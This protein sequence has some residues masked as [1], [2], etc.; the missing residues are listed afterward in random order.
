QEEL[1]ERYQQTERFK[2]LDG[3]AEE[4]NRAAEKASK[5]ADLT[6]DAEDAVFWSAHDL[7]MELNQVA[8]HA[9]VD[10]MN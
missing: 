5:E 2:H 10:C 8:I 6:Y 9:V 3:I 7:A 4:A 1:W